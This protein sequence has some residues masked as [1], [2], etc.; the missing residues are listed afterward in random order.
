M[1][2]ASSNIEGGHGPT[3][4]C[5]GVAHQF[6]DAVKTVNPRCDDYETQEKQP[7]SYCLE[8]INCV[9]KREGDHESQTRN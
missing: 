2:V 1:V 9:N 7:L 3:L 4:N 6:Q 5:R 8:V